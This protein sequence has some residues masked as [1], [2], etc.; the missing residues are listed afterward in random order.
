MQ[1]SCSTLLSCVMC[2]HFQDF[3]FSHFTLIDAHLEQLKEGVEDA[4]HNRGAFTAMVVK[5]TG[6]RDTV[7]KQ[8]IGAYLNGCMS[9][10]QC[11]FLYLHARMHARTHTHTHTHTHRLLSGSAW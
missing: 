7:G 4:C 11:M 3:F 6:T 1:C 2:R 5:V 10:Q 9:I 8:N